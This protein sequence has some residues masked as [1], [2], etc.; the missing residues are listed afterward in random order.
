MGELC[1]H[2][3]SVIEILYIE[4]A[5]MPL[6]NINFS[7]TSRARL[8]QVVI[9]EC[10]YLHYVTVFLMLKGAVYGSCIGHNV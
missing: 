10:H 1:N 4:T 8:R 2:E 7:V 3:E 9:R 5:Y 6:G